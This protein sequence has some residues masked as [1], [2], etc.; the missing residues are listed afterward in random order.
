MI[1]WGEGGTQRGGVSVAS[2]ADS[3]RA[4]QRLR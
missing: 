3:S 2:V 4:G 1:Y